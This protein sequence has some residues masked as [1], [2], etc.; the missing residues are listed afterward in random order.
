MAGTTA[1]LSELIRDEIWSQRVQD[2]LQEELFGQSLVEFITDFPDGDKITIPTLNSL[3]AR[4]Y[5]EN[6]DITVD[7]PTVG[8]FQLTITEYNQAGIVITDKMK[9]DTFYMSVLIQKF[10]EQVVRAIMERLES[11][12]MLLHKNQTSNDAN[13][14]NGRPHRFVASGTSS[15]MTL[16]DV[17][18]AKLSFDK[19]LV[20]KVGRKAIVDPSVSAEL[21]GIDNVIRQ[22]V[23][24]PNDHIKNAFGTTSA[25]GRYIGFDWFES[26][27]LDEAT[28]L[29]HVTGGSLIA[30]L[31]LGDEALI[32]AMRL[33]PEIEKFRQATRKRDVVHVTTRYGLKLYRNVA[34]VTVLTGA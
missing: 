13:N 14:I 29:N 16:A 33:M 19:G 34:L 6:D 28:A 31:F 17:I 11:D 21:L 27:M 15:V 9:Q 3:S 18:K 12:I 25:I 8:E 26:N 32:G 4:A 20:S 5:V 1:N 2:E 24:G 30:N 23:Y 10:P 22:D 7:D